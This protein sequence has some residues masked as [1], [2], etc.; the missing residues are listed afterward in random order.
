MFTIYLISKST[1]EI[2]DWTF[3]E[4]LFDE[5]LKEMEDEYHNYMVNYGWLLLGRS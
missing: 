2:I 4:D 5:I 3:T 1:G